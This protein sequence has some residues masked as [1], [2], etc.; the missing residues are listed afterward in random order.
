[1]KYD[2]ICPME[3]RVSEDGPATVS[4]IGDFSPVTKEE[5]LG[6]SISG[7]VEYLCSYTEKPGFEGFSSRGLARVFSDCVATAPD[8]FYGIL[9]QRPNCH[10]CT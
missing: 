1:M 7:I 2:E 6:M 9:K 4:F 10:P 5:L 3:V 8:K